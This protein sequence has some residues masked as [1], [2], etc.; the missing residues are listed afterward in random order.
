MLFL[1]LFYLVFLLNRIGGDRIQTIS[2]Q[3]GADIQNANI[4]SN[5]QDII[6]NTISFYYIN[7]LEPYMTIYGNEILD[8]DASKVDLSASSIY[9]FKRY[10]PV[11]VNGT[12][13]YVENPYYDGEM[14][15]E[16]NTYTNDLFLWLS[17]IGMLSMAKQIYTN[18]S[19]NYAEQAAYFAFTLLSAASSFATLVES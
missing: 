15:A 14:F 8:S 18:L 5:Y 16:T 13:T 17:P 4:V 10:T 6:D 9:S 12:V 19:S 11:N 7:G 1:F 2:I 3:N